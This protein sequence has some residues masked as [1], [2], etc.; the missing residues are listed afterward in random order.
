MVHVGT[1]TLYKRRKENIRSFHHPPKAKKAGDLNFLN[2]R[3]SG[4]SSDHEVYGKIV[5]VRKYK[6]LAALYRLVKHNVL[7]Q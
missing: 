2:V 3:R 7:Y 1:G 4:I 5:K 6:V